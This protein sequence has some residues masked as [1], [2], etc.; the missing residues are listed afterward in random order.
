[1]LGSCTAG[2]AY[3]PALCDQ[4]IMINNKSSVFLGGPPLVFAATGEKI[5]VEELG[6]SV[7]DNRG[8]IGAQ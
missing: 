2:G 4:T 6:K 3:I 7:S 5:S 8:R 1:M